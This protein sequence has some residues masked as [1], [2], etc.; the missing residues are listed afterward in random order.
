[1]SASVSP[2]CGRASALLS[3]FTASTGVSEDTGSPVNGDRSWGGDEGDGEGVTG[4]VGAGVAAACLTRT[5]PLDT[6]MAPT[7]RLA[8]TKATPLV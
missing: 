2:V 8:R 5:P 6:S 3:I 4:W 1:M 7:T